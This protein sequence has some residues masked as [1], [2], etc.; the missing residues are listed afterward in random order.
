MTNKSLLDEL[1]NSWE[2]DPK[3]ANA[4]KKAMR[5]RTLRGKGN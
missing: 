4:I 2:P 3:L 5:W 1:I